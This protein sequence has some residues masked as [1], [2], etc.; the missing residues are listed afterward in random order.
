M[1]TS[2]LTGQE[3]ECSRVLNIFK[4]QQ[5]ILG[6]CH[7]GAEL[8]TRGRDWGDKSRPDFEKP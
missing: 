2:M 8:R 3:F 4:E 6:G 5:M 1:E 7:L